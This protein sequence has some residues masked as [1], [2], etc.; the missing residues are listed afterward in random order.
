MGASQTRRLLH[1][2]LERPLRPAVARPRNLGSV[3]APAVVPCPELEQEQQAPTSYATQSR[4]PRHHRSAL[5]LVHLQRRQRL[6]P[7]SFRGRD[8]HHSPKTRV[9]PVPRI[10]F[11][12][13]RKRSAPLSQREQTHTTDAITKINKV[14]L[15]LAEEA[16]EHA[17]VEAGQGHLFDP[18]AMI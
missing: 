10:S 9:R 3:P 15:V 11:V 12:E 13:A 14:G 6:V 2:R 16:K 18:I 7:K 1:S 5:A 4:R 17:R 8:P